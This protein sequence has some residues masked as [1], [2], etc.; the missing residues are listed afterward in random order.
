MKKNMRIIFIMMFVFLL[1]G[2]PV[3]RAVAKS[4]WLRGGLIGAGTGA[5]GGGFGMYGFCR[6][7]DG[8]AGD[9]SLDL[10]SCSALFVP[11][12]AVGGGAVGFGLGAALGSIFKKPDTA[13]QVTV[14]PISNNYG[15]SMTIPF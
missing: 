11:I 10:G 8:D 12:G 9:E 13:V 3:K 6:A 5:L 7:I 1:A 4:Y 14:D 2:L 15:A